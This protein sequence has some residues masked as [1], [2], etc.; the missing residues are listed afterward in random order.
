MTAKHLRRIVIFALLVLVLLSY[1]CAVYTS[2]YGRRGDLTRERFNTYYSIPEGAVDGIILGTSGVDRYWLGALG[3]KEEGITMFP[4]SSGHQPMFLTKFVIEEALKH[5]PDIKT[6]VIEVRNATQ[7]PKE[8]QDADVRRVVENMRPSPNRFKATKYAMDYLDEIGCTTVDTSDISHYF[9]L[10][11]YHAG[12]KDYKLKDY[13]NLYP[14]TP[15]LGY[16]VARGY[17]YVSRPEEPTVVTD[18]TTT[19]DKDAEDMLNDLM[20]YCE[21]LDAK[22]IFIATP[23]SADALTQM[24]L[25]TALQL[26]ASRGFDTINFNTDEMYDKIGWNFDEDQYNINHANF[27]G[28]VKFTRYF[29]RYMKENYNMPDRRQDADQSQYATFDD[30][31]YATLEQVKDHAPEYYDKMFGNNER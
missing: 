28:A 25:N 5:Q 3:W 13:F 9:T 19:L 4:L 7:S 21:T 10:A 16:Q 8:V 6:I 18:E 23:Q 1:L 14:K 15:Y 26:A 22:V 11:K 20:D 12:W 2:P 17:M 30:A 27:Y 24:Q 31:Y 29:A